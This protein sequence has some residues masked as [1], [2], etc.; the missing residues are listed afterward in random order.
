MFLSSQFK[1]RRFIMTAFIAGCVYV[2]SRCFKLQKFVVSTRRIGQFEPFIKHK[3]LTRDVIENKDL[4]V[5]GD[6]HGCYDEMI[7]MLDEVKQRSVRKFVTIF[8]GDMIN[9]GPKNIEVLEFIMR[10]KDIYCVRGNHEQSILRKISKMKEDE[11]FQLKVCW[12]LFE[13][14]YFLKPHQILYCHRFIRDII[15]PCMYQRYYIALT[16]PKIL[17]CLVSIRD[18]IMT[19]L[20]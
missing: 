11:E 5:V 9:K 16:V 3:T 20:Y 4:L 18:I 19:C 17:Y 1:P 15:L 10:E 7:K 14:Q 12:L 6:V 13:V 8:V 2:L